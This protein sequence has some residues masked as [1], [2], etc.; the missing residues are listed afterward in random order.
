MLFRSCDYRK[1]GVLLTGLAPAAAVPPDLFAE[2]DGPA[3]DALMATV[4]RLNG[5]FGPRTVFLAAEGVG[6]SWAMRR[7]RQSP[8]YTTC[9]SEL[10]KAG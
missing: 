6:R 9:W 4:D 1:A 10:P 8:R 5:R 2:G 3:R 7:N